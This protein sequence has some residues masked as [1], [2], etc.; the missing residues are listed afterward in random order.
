MKLIQ[1]IKPFFPFKITYKFANL[2]SLHCTGTGFLS[3]FITKMEV[4]KPFILYL[5]FLM[6]SIPLKAQES[7]PVHKN[8][9]ITLAQAYINLSLTKDYFEK[10]SNERLSKILP[11]ET[12]EL[13]SITDSTFIKQNHTL[14]NFTYSILYFNEAKL[15]FKNKSKTIERSVLIKWHHNLKKAIAY[16]NLSKYINEGNNEFYQLINFEENSYNELRWNIYSLKSEFTPYFNND[17][18]LDF[19]KIFYNSKR[20]KKYDFDKLS[21]YAS[22]YDLALDLSIIENRINYEFDNYNSIDHMYKM[23]LKLDLITRYLQLKYIASN[24]YE[25]N[26]SSAEILQ[27]YDSYDGFYYDIIDNTKKFEEDN[28]IRKELNPE[29]CKSLYN[30][31]QKK[32]PINK[33]TDSDGDGVIDNVESAYMARPKQYFFPNPAPLPSAKAT[34][35]NFKPNLTILGT[36]DKDISS[37]F[38]NAGYKNKLYYYYH[39]DGYAMTT[40]L[41]KFNKDGTAIEDSKRWVKS[42]GGEGKFSY[43]EIFKSLFFET[44]SEFR[45]FAIIIASKEVRISNESLTPSGAEMLIKNSHPTLPEEL[46]N[47]T[48]PNKNLTVLVYHF[49]QNDIGEVPM[50]DLSGKIKVH[51]HLKKAGLSNLIKN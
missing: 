8:D 20:S 12:N 15:L 1:L 24:Q 2:H 28:F 37:I 19:K 41:E 4:Y 49:H 40:S 50:L 3:K 42:L 47:K 43:Y 9:S 35:N 7:H 16:Y 13:K 27:I 14:Y 45:M 17:I 44:E 5:I 48:L 39:L 25:K 26:L 51:D 10:I 11:F 6:A 30:E 32:Y 21:Y 34:F 38:I 18:Y 31:L 23:D 29:V 33:T 22:I 46:K 36:V